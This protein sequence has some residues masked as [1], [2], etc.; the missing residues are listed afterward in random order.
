MC[1]C[2]P[3]VPV[4]CPSPLSGPDCEHSPHPGMESDDWCGERGAGG[5]ESGMGGGGSA[6]PPLW[7]SWHLWGLEQGV[8]DGDGLAGAQDAEF[9][10]GS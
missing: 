5:S 9:V 7:E 2:V 10:Q 4:A 3:G 1:T 6:P 8:G